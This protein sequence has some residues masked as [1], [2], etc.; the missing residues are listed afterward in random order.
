ML[1]TERSAARTLPMQNL[2]KQSIIGGN[3][4]L[5]QAN[6]KGDTKKVSGF[7]HVVTT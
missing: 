1:A 7:R 5:S 2:T 3:L 4:N 6:W